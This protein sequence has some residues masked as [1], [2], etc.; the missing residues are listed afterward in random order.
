MDEGRGKRGILDLGSGSEIG[1]RRSDIRWAVA[2]LVVFAVAL[3]IGASRTWAYTRTK[4]CYEERYPNPDG[5]A[6]PLC[7]ADQVPRAFFW[8]V[9][10]VRYRQH[11]DGTAEFSSEEGSVDPRMRELVR[12]AFETWNAVGCSDFTFVEGEPT[13]TRF[14]ADVAEGVEG[15]T[16]GVYWR[17]EEWPYPSGPMM[18]EAFALTTVTTRVTG[19]II[20][21]DIEVN[22]AR[23]DVANLSPSEPMP[24]KLDLLNTFVH[25]AGHVLGLDH[26]GD[27]ETTMYHRA[28]LGEVDKRT[29]AQDD[30]DGLCA[31]YPSERAD[32]RCE[33]SADFKPGPTAEEERATEPTCGATG[34]GPGALPGSPVWW[35]GLVA[36]A[37]C[38]RS[39]RRR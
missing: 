12:E 11:V 29:L 32:R 21:A 5:V 6:R 15:N 9:R 27:R 16:N 39:R 7:E 4:T 17:D 36:I 35:I 8:P 34:R 14:G 33:T 20:D 28:S 13:S 3:M 37:G 19:R 23:F 1:D 2:G 18:R 30:V 38:L 10:C 31:I 24:N 22:S 25:E 26:T